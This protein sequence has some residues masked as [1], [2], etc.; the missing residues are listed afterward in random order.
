MPFGHKG[1]RLPSAFLSFLALSLLL[2]YT[3]RHEQPPTLRTSRQEVI[4]AS[5]ELLREWEAPR[6]Q[7]RFNS[8]EGENDWQAFNSGGGSRGI[9]SGTLCQPIRPRESRGHVTAY[10]IMVHSEETLEGARLLVEQIYDPLD[11]FLVHVDAKLNG[12]RLF[13][14]VNGMEV[15]ENVEFV[16]DNE[17]VDV[18]W[19]DI[20]SSLSSLIEAFR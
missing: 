9:G 3:L 17:R 10:L 8:Q 2:F 1:R 16:P 4:T 12:T 5:E 11:L 19:G 18:K 20:V 7:E 14:T 6:E 15:C 13:N